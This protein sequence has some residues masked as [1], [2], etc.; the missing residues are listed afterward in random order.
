[1]PPRRLRDLIMT[2]ILSS[3]CSSLIGGLL[4]TPLAAAVTAA[5]QPNLIW[6]MADDLGYG[7]L[8]CYGE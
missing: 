6:I 4:L 7:E 3:I 1:M 5:E 2:R 8:G